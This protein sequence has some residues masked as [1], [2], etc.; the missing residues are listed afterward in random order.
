MQ[1]PRKLSEAIGDGASVTFMAERRN[2]D[3]RDTI[4]FRNRGCGVAF[5]V[6]PGALCDGGG[7]AF[8]NDLTLLS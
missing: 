4:V 5:M 3:G 6:D 2:V 1:T 7:N 8:V